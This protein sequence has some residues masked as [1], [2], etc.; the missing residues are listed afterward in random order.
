M[1][2]DG[3]E[4]SATLLSIARY[5]WFYPLSLRET[6]RLRVTLVGRGGFCRVNGCSDVLG[7]VTMR[8]NAACVDS[9]KIVITVFMINLLFN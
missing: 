5:E 6:Y 1:G 8:F 4:S 9:V 7:A 2:E 3:K